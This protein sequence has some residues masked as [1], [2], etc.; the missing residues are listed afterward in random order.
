M[1]HS[2]LGIYVAMRN[3]AHPPSVRCSYECS[4]TAG[5]LSEYSVRGDISA[6]S[7]QTIVPASASTWT[8]LKS[9]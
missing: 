5:R 2:Y 9:M 8:C 3:P 1:V 7:G 6:P 4:G